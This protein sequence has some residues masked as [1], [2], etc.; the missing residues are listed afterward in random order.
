[1]SL[2][3][4]MSNLRYLGVGLWTRLVDRFEEGFEIH[5]N[6]HSYIVNVDSSK[7]PFIH[8]G[9]QNIALGVNNYQNINPVYNLGFK[10]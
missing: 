9:L 7:W 1:M 6:S 3:C 5:V 10:K 8:Q 4:P 2:N